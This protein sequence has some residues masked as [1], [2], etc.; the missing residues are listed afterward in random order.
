MDFEAQ[1]RRMAVLCS[2]LCPPIIDSH[3]TQI[4]S[5]SNCSSDSTRDLVEN[6]NFQK[7]CVFCKIIQGN[8]PAFKIY[9]DDMCLCILDTSPLSRGH[10]L[11]IPKHHFC[12]LDATPPS[13]IAAM[14]SKIPFISNAI[15]KATGCDSFNLL[16]NNGAA[17]GQV[18]FHTHIHIIPRKTHDRLWASEMWKFHCRA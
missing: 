15:K 16:V 14:C 10:S 7:D 3:N 9:E 8:S 5:T 1:R 13:V 17:A 11:L 6:P 12:A 2:H 18:I 4:V